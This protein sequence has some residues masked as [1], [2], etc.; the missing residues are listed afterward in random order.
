MLKANRKWIIFV[1]AF[2]LV[3]VGLTV[4]LNSRVFAAEANFLNFDKEV[5]DVYCS[6]ANCDGFYIDW[7]KTKLQ[8]IDVS[9]KPVGELR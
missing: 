1:I 4:N 3:I 2:V 7:N 5:K 9:A 6:E 8:A